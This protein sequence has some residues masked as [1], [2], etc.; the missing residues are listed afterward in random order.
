MSQEKIKK[1]H[2]DDDLLASL[3]LK[4]DYISAD[5]LSPELRAVLKGTNTGTRY[6]DTELRNRIISLEKNSITK[7]EENSFAK[8]SDVM[9][10]EETRD[11][12]KSELQAAETDFQTKL[13]KKLDTDTDGGI[14]EAM[15]SSDLQHKVNARFNNLHD[16]V[17]E[18]QMS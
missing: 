15:L 16:H 12:I 6:D 14:D 9:T 5:D 1:Y 17:S 8:K 11:V 7:E 3:R 4:D 13:D 10:P 2:L 18:D